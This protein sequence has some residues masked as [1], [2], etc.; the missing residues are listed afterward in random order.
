VK[1]RRI[2]HLGVLVSDAEAAA[3]GFSDLLDLPV[4]RRER[5]GDELDIVFVPCGESDVELLEPLAPDG[6]NAAWL[7]E[8]GPGIQHVA[9]EVDDLEAALAELRGR[10]VEPLGAAPRPG[11]GDTLIA[12]LDPSRFGGVLVELCQPRS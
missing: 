9:F 11:A 3:A 7:A 2:D 10:G 4:A 5:Y 1:V 12:F 8:H 6:D